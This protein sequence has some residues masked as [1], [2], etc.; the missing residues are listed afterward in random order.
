[1]DEIKESFDKIKRDINYLNQEIQKIKSELNVL[2]SQLVNL[3]FLFK[4]FIADFSKNKTENQINTTNKELFRALKDQNLR[5]SI[6]NQGVSTD[7]QTD[8]QTQKKDYLKENIDINSADYLLDSLDNLKKEIRLKFKRLT[9]QE[10]IVFSSIYNIE[11]RLGYAN[12]KI[13][14]ENLN[15]TESSIRDYVRRLVL[16]GIPLEKEKV[17]NKE[18][19][20]KISPNL[21]KITTLDTIQRLR[22]I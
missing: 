20:I 21:R 9:N 13:I 10:M 6:G 4:G 1:M 11:Q 12:Y 14:A 17:N 16:K 19:L 15:L 8:I 18:I 5:I 3:P 7:R 2:N 22:N